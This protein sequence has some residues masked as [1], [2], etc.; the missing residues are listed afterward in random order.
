MVFSKFTV[1]L[2]PNRSTA[3]SRIPSRMRAM[4]FYQLFSISSK[5]RIDRSL[6]SEETALIFCWF[7]HRRLSLAVTRYPGG[8]PTEL[9]PPRVPSG[10]RRSRRL[11]HLLLASVQHFGERPRPSGF[12]RVPVGSSNMKTPTGRPSG[13]RPA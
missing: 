13:A 4:K 6:K 2:S 1:V 10:T 3:L 11:E 12:S 7:Q 5:S 8:A 9:G